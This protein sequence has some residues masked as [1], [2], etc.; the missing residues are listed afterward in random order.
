MS[1]FLCT[2]PDNCHI[3]KNVLWWGMFCGVCAKASQAELLAHGCWWERCLGLEGFQGWL[4]LLCCLSQEWPPWCT[5]SS[6]DGPLRAQPVRGTHQFCS[7][8]DGQPQRP[9][10]V[11]FLNATGPSSPCAQADPSHLP[12]ASL[13]RFCLLSHLLVHTLCMQ[14][15]QK[16]T[17]FF[18][19]RLFLL[20]V[21]VRERSRTLKD[22]LIIF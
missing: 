16:M 21:L 10:G 9:E 2:Q 11:W 8:P 5:A 13:C 20:L 22:L 1:T 19:S 4:H 7:T 14:T 3:I 15:A 6:R 17:R 12:Q 18:F